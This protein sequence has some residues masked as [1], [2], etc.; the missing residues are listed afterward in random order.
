MKIAMIADGLSYGTWDWRRLETGLGGSEVMFCYFARE[1]GKSND[2]TCYTRNDSPGIGFNANWR[3]LTE[4][5]GAWDAVVSLRVPD[6]LTGVDAKVKAFWANDQRFPSLPPVVTR[7]DCNLIITISE[8]QTNNFKYMYPSIPSELY[9][10]SS[11]GVAWDEF[12]MEIPKDRT[13][14]L[15]LSTPERG[16]RNFLTLWPRIIAKAP[17]ANLVVTSGFQLYGWSDQQ[18]ADASEGIYEAIGRMPRVEY[19]GPLT[20]KTYN[21]TVRG[22]GLLL[23]PTAYEEQCC[24]SALEAAAGR[25]AI[26]STELAALK[27]RVRSGF[28]GFLIK[29]KPGNQQY[30]DEF[31]DRA[32]QL[33]GNRAMQTEMGRAGR[34]LAKR[35]DYASLAAAWQSRFEEML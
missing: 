27:E 16:L 7:G 25:C 19:T 5:G 29:G 18:S 35:H 2:V 17:N 23:Y 26:V 21:R 28:N 31:I 6:R 11:A 10:Q 24:I 13:Q 30:D 32:V 8:H 33:L 9:L 1:L 34:K 15:Y 4:F 22:S 3:D 12:A 20:R 14:C